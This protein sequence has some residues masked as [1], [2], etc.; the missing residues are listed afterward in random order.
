[1]KQPTDSDRSKRSKRSRP[2]GASSPGAKQLVSTPVPGALPASAAAASPSTIGDAELFDRA[3]MQWHFGDWE[4][5]AALDWSIIEA[6]PKRALLALLASTASQQLG[7]A[8]IARRYVIQALEWGCDKRQAA[9]VLISGVHNTLARAAAMR[10]EEKRALNH[11]ME[12]VHGANGDPR[13]ACQARSVREV[14]RLNLLDQAS[15]MIKSLVSGDRGTPVDNRTAYDQPAEPAP[16]SWVLR[17]AKNVHSYLPVT[18][19]SHVAPA[20]LAGRRTI[21]I[22]GMRHSGSTALFNI[23]RLALDQKGLTYRSFYSEGNNSEVLSD[24]D[25]D[26]LLIKTH[27]LRDDVLARADVII[28][29]RRDLRDT[30]ASAV[31]RDFPLLKKLN[32]AVEYAKYN[33]SLHD[34][35]LPHTDYEFIYEAFMAD[36]APE[37]E[38]VLAFLG[39]GNVDI[40]A[41]SEQ[42]VNLPTDQYSTTLLSPIHIT[43]PLRAMSYRDSLEEVHLSR[44]NT[45]HASW[46]RRYG[47]DSAAG[48]P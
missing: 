22:A 19:T 34:I 14:A 37:T 5:L 2:S 7:H 48:E 33:R 30:V 26:L 42:A 46:L 21:V 39:L 10:Q 38:R 32:G 35:W 18:Q 15:H 31:R 41:I 40:D 17:A 28:T 29:T 11:F 36:P 20:P 27:E 1:M 25:E 16:N 23:V 43:D 3:R 9:Q 8:D 6:H 12:S 45:D 13:L 47:Y 24:P 4:S 44:I